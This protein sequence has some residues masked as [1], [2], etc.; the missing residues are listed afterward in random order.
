MLPAHPEPAAPAPWRS[1]ALSQV[2]PPPSPVALAR[3]RARAPRK[4]LVEGA[5]PALSLVPHHPA[6]SS[7]LPLRPLPAPRWSGAPCAAPHSYLRSTGCRKKQFESAM[8]LEVSM[9]QKIAAMHA[10][11]P[12]V[13]PDA[14]WHPW[15]ELHLAACTD[16][17]FLLS[18]VCY[19]ARRTHANT[20]AHTHV[21][22]T[23]TAPSTLNLTSKPSRDHSFPQTQPRS[24][25][26]CCR[27][28][29]WHK[30]WPEQQ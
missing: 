10:A 22:T 27:L 11:R 3:G 13:W 30:G 28:R 23:E 26:R 1:R 17:A 5:K 25:R 2:L 19:A 7:P 12:A 15:R 24:R 20:F 8:A 21:R 29:R 18:L 6:R 14:L 4:G 9:E 16:C